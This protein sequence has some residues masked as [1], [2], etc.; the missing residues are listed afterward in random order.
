M[1]LNFVEKK[2]K[3]KIAMNDIGSNIGQTPWAVWPGR[4]F[5]NFVGRPVP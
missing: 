3:K 1:R 2:K 5:H 4:G